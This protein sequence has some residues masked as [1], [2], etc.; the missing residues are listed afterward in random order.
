M[1]GTDV[2]V[3]AE[4]FGGLAIAPVHRFDHEAPADGGGCLPWLGPD[5]GLNVAFDVFVQKRLDRTE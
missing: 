3:E 1:V 4:H 2:V 5:P